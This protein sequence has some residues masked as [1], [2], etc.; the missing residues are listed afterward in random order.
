MTEQKKRFADKYFETLNGSKSAVYAGYSESTSR[1]IAYNL[2]QEPEVEEYLTKLR[3]KYE[4]KTGITKEKWLNELA[5]VGFS[6]IQ[7]F[8]EDSNN[9]KDISKI[10][11]SKAASVSSVK[12][13]VIE[14]EFGTKEVVEFKLHDKLNALEKIGRH[15]GYFEKDNEQLKSQTQNIINLGSGVKPDETT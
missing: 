15:L 3:E 2:L 14:G 9:I 7:D 10:E 1:Q 13:T 5:E 4:L 8:I 11:K 12:K 6:N